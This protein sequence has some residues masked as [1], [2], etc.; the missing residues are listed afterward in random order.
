MEPSTLKPTTDAQ[1]S[2]RRHSDSP[3]LWF[4]VILGSVVVHLGAFGILRLLLMAGVVGLPSAN[5][6]IPIDVIAIA[7]PPVKVIAPNATSTNRIAPKTATTATQKPTTTNS[8]MQNRKTPI[9]KAS[10][11]SSQSPPREKKQLPSSNTAKNTTKSP[12]STS[13]PKPSGENKPKT[14]T[15]SPSSKNNQSDAGKSSPNPTPTHSSTQPV[16]PS[17]NDKPAGNFVASL[18]T[19]ILGE[20]ANAGLD[21]ND[22][23][24]KDKLAEIK[25]SNSQF[26][27]DDLAELGIKVE[28]VLELRV[29]VVIEKTG[30]ATVL[31]NST[32]VQSG[33]INPDQAETLVKKILEQW[34]F[35]PTLMAGQPVA[36]NYNI[37]LTISPAP[38]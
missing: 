4:A 14:N 11:T 33:N 7:K 30:K 3:G 38:K 28:Q 16:S 18:R 32:Q 31:P 24:R 2:E 13:S 15:N 25:S 34:Q 10:T 27:N 20:N 29:A 1:K 17:P 22:P 8:G 26:S 19:L 36:G 37:Q 21:P 12:T 5:K 6:I 9:S 35:N 23:N